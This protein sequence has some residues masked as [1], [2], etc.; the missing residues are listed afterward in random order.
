MK[1]Q[2]VRHLDQSQSSFGRNGEVIYLFTQPRKDAKTQR[3]EALEFDYT[4][5]S[6][7]ACINFIRQKIWHLFEIKDGRAK[8]FYSAHVKKWKPRAEKKR[9]KYIP[10]SMQIKITEVN[11]VMQDIEKILI[12]SRC[13]KIIFEVIS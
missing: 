6:R 2:E 7:D 11:K 12:S 9:R 3:L 10:E 5:R 8:I 1:P 13:T 4:G